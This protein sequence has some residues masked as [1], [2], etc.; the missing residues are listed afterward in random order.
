MSPLHTINESSTL[1]EEKILMKDNAALTKAKRRFSELVGN[2]IAVLMQ[3]HGFSRERAVRLVLG[4]INLGGV[5][6]SEDKVRMR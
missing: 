5:I 4:E 2:G 3:Q 1:E 6:P